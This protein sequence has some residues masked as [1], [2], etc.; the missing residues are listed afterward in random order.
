[1]LETT[2]C[3]MPSYSYDYSL[4]VG[5]I[6]SCTQTQIKISQGELKITLHRLL[7]VI[8][9]QKSTDHLQ[10]PVLNFLYSDT[11]FHWKKLARKEMRA[12]NFGSFQIFC[13]SALLALVEPRLGERNIYFCRPLKTKQKSSIFDKKTNLFLWQ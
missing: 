8:L 6:L 10:L 4:F 3:V 2:A 12:K 1:M 7:V 13:G 11:G 5:T 9:S